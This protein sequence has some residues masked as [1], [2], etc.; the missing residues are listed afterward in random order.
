M[1][2]LQNLG[3]LCGYAPGIRIGY[4]LAGLFMLLDVQAWTLRQRR[5]NKAKVALMQAQAKM[6]AEALVDAVRRER[7]PE[8]A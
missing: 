1:N 5:I 6:N 3:A 8:G 7:A 4:G 2:E